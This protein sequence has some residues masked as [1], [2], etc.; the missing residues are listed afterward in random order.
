MCC[1]NFWKKVTVFSITLMIGFFVAQVVTSE[2]PINVKVSVPIVE[3]NLSSEDVS[4]LLPQS[5]SKNCVPADS[6]LKYRNL[7]YSPERNVKL[8]REVNR[9]KH[10]K[11][12]I[13][14]LNSLLTELEDYTA[15][16][17]KDNQIEK[18]KKKIQLKLKNL[19]EN[20]GKGSGLL[21]P[22]EYYQEQNLLYL[23]KC[24]DN[25]KSMILIP[26]PQKEK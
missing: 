8:E 26:S 10:L 7:P 19:E 13:A 2:K 14:K 6:N 20:I 5:K 21:P 4:P 12:E 3:N 15:K 25:G 17:S 16:E 18:S 24:F 22:V 1:N 9:L 11:N 23:E